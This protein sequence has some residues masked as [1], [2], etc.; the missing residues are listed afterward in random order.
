MRSCVY[1]RKELEPTNYSYY[2]S[3]E[4]KATAIQEK[5][6]NPLSLYG[7]GS[8]DYD[9][10]VHYRS[11]CIRSMGIEPEILEKAEQ[12]E[13]SQYEEDPS[14]IIVEDTDELFKVVFE[15]MNSPIYRKVTNKAN[16]RKRRK[17]N[18]KSSPRDQKGSSL[19]YPNYNYKLN[20]N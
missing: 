6:K 4:C 8:C 7:S 10:D 3:D 20:L 19:K 13:C 11:G 9:R 14:R 16:N 5:N 12:N 17:K 2:C 15:E 1:C 18:N